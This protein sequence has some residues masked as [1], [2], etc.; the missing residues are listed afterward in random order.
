MA[1]HS[2]GLCGRSLAAREGDTASA[3]GCVAATRLG[4]G[5]CPKRQALGVAMLRASHRCSGSQEEPGGAA[6]ALQLE[7]QRSNR[8]VGK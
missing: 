7:K 8:G 5:R 3:L 2:A 6:A 1:E 4:N